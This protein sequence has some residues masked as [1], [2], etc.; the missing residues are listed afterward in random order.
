MTQIRR[1]VSLVLGN[2]PAFNEILSAA[3]M[4]EQKMECRSENLVMHLLIHGTVH[5]DGEKDLGPIIASLSL[6][7]PATMR[8]RPIP[9]RWYSE[10]P[11]E[12]IV[13]KSPPIV[14][15][16]TLRHGDVLIMEGAKIQEYY[17][18]GNVTHTHHRD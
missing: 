3:Y 17:Q 9:S 2:A 4:V 13:R 11:V 8:F 15:T 6:G 10:E 5:S 16:L 7:L 12:G 1:Q 14:L 18:V